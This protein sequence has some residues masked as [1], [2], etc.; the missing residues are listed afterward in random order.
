MP[1]SPE[2]LIEQLKRQINHVVRMVERN[3]GYERVLTPL[4][5]A[6]YETV[7]FAECATAEVPREEVAIRLEAALSTL[8]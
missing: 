7:L 2:V 6:A 4:V 5:D 1:E 3:P 8:Q